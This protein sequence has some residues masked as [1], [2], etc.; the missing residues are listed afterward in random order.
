MEWC[1][2]VMDVRLEVAK[3]HDH[4]RKVWFAVS[5]DGTHRHRR[6]CVANR[7]KEAAVDELIWIW[8]GPMMK[9]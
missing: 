6:L 4:L 2:V 3:V 8:I 7:E 1:P 5:H 9:K